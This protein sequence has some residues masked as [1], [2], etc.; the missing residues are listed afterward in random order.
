M[1]QYRVAV[2]E[3][4]MLETF[5]DMLADASKEDDDDDL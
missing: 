1:E 2:A 3:L 5:E 4:R